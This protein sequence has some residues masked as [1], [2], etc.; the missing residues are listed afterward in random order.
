M[1]SL[2]GAYAQGAGP[3]VGTEDVRPPAHHD[4]RGPAGFHLAFGVTLAGFVLGSNAVALAGLL[5]LRHRPWPLTGACAAIG[6]GTAIIA[7]P[8]PGA[9]PAPVVPLVTTLALP[10]AAAASTTALL[11][12]YLGPV[13][14]PAT[15]PVA[16]PSGRTC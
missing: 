12:P 6:T 2:V 13:G 16:P 3:R 8:V 7:G 1:K 9:V 14:L 11:G 10:A 4:A 5:R 15:P